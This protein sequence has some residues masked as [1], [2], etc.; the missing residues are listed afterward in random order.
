M[1][2]SSVFALVL[3]VL[4]VSKVDCAVR[5]VA[6]GGGLQA[7]GLPFSELVGRG[8][9]NSSGELSLAA[10]ANAMSASDG[11]RRARTVAHEKA[12][13][14]E[15]RTKAAATWSG[16]ATLP[17]GAPSTPASR[18]GGDAS[19]SDITNAMERSRRRRSQIF[20]LCIITPLGPCALIALALYL[21]ASQPQQ[22]SA[23]SLPPPSRRSEECPA[24]G[25]AVA[26]H[27]V[28]NTCKPAPEFTPAPVG[29]P[30]W[31][32]APGAGAY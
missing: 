20:A 26:G 9:H 24:R 2:R 30:A 7:S 19:W 17:A 29:I 28:E 8:P 12:A 4:P 11:G 22:G 27:V 16:E 21:G 18:L 15:V 10:M 1:T 31:E 14:V 32:T 23:S 5:K 25:P 6:V 3:F 13:A